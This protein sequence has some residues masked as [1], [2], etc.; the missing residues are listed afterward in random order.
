MEKFRQPKKILLAILLLTTFL[1]LFRLDYPHA[2]VFDEVYHA[3]T[4]KEYLAGHKEAW[5]WWTTPPPGVAYEWTHPPLGK[6]IMTFSMFTLRS[7]D[8]WAWRLPG[9][10]LGILSVYL[11]YLLGLSLFKKESVG[12]LSAFIFSL[13]GLNFVQSRTGMVDI[14][15]VAAMLLCLLLIQKNKFLLATVALGLAL[16][17]KWTGIYLI[18]MVMI[19]LLVRKNWHQIPYFIFIP[20]SLYMLSYLPF[21]ISGHN[22]NLFI[23]LQ[24]QMWWYHTN[25]KATHDYASPWWSWPLNLYPVWYYVEYS[26]NQIANIFASGNPIMFWTGAIAII[27][28]CWDFF[29]SF[30]VKIKNGLLVNL[31][32][33]MSGHFF[34]LL[35]YFIFWLPWAFSP[36]IMFLYH[37]APSIP[38]MALGLGYQLSLL[39]PDRE[40]RKLLFWILGAIVLGF[41]FIY[42]FITGI[43]LPKNLMELFFY[44]N[45]TKN[46]FK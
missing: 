39:L 36:R 44:T 15:F 22:F 17:S 37:Y 9:A 1:H 43:L 33:N 7:T 11:I 13:D 28:T 25:L 12:L 46:P 45:I 35:G 8:S 23:E 21:F 19:L 31:P 40:N 32:K 42:P 34:I 10:L 30:G 27:L 41:I 4:A 2:Y 6:E 18:G 3:F 26:N 16:A 20:A 38:F 24:K 29:K 5:E 14:Y